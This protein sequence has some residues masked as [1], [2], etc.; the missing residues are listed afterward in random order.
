[1]TRQ[2]ESKALGVITAEEAEITYSPGLLWPWLRAQRSCCNTGQ[3]VVAVP[4]CGSG[5]LGWYKWDKANKQQLL[6]F[7]LQYPLLGTSILQGKVKLGV[8]N[9]LTALV[10]RLSSWSKWWGKP[11]PCLCHQ[12]SVAKLGKFGSLVDGQ[13]HQCFESVVW[14]SGTKFLKSHY[15]KQKDIIERGMVKILWGSEASFGMS[16][17]NMVFKTSVI[18]LCRTCFD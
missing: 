13:I 9:Q 10:T 1:M 3:H 2:A 15:S 8:K 14:K 12:G 11:S 5:P 18:S 4:C 6:K 7:G 17:Q 16:L